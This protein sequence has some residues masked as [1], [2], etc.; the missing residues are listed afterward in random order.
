MYFYTLLVYNK[1]PTNPSQATK[2]PN[3]HGKL[4]GCSSLCG[5]SWVRRNSV[6][7]PEP[8]SRPPGPAQEVLRK[9]FGLEEFRRGQWDVIECVLEGRDA[10]SVMPTGGGKSL[11]YQ[12]PALVRPG[13]AIVVSPLISLMDDQVRQL[14][15]RGIASGALHSGLEVDAKRAVFAEMRSSSH[16]I[17]YLSP[18]RTQSDAFLQW[19]AQNG[20]KISLVAIDEA[21]C[22]SQWGHDFREEYAKLK[23]LRLALP[24]SVP[25]LALTATATPS[26][27]NDIVRSLGLRN[28]KTVVQGFYRPNL[29]YQVVDVADDD[30]KM[31]WL[32]QAI[33][34]NPV[35][36]VIIYAGTRKQAHALSKWLSRFFDGVDYYHAGLSA[37][38]RSNKQEEFA[39]NKLRI[40]V[41][42]NA[43]GMGI[44][45]P[46][47]RLVVHY[48]IPANIESLYQEMGRAGR[49]GL[50][51]T[52]LTLYAKKDKGLQA[53][54]ITSSNAPASITKAKWLALN[55]LTE[56]LETD[57]CRQ[58]GVLTYFRDPNRMKRC[59]HCDVCAPAETR[60][61]LKP[62]RAPEATDQ[63]IR[64]K[65]SKKSQ[66]KHTAETSARAFDE[67]DQMLLGDLKA[68]RLKY[69]QEHDVPAFTVFSNKALEDLVAKKPLSADQLMQVYGFG[70]HKVTHFGE[71]ILGVIK[72]W[73]SP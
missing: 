72:S 73:Q 69:A 58:A 52:C 54:F 16:F 12:L 45:H 29:Y 41:A 30:A 42:T 15:A 14:K 1:V 48:Q 26:V 56:F 32:H 66:S 22:V 6:H 40:L 33:E 43:F 24:P 53:Y 31:R 50:P 47:V 10:V 60:R 65:L 51:S 9:A 49:D 57:E 62:A 5:S 61:V 55:T 23:N 38:S 34:Q 3:G 19:L 35:G 70:E 64:K 13:I 27:L 68:W 67:R 17:L 46:D 20:S 39:Q 36:R 4:D 7:A 11:C 18:E 71:A 44:D 21:H 8:H 28:P 25:M 59:G 2:I 37:E 63:K